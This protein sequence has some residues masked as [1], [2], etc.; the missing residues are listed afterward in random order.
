MSNKR[1]VL[2]LYP[3]AVPF[4]IRHSFRVAEYD[5]LEKIIAQDRGMAWNYNAICNDD[6]VFLAS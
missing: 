4:F 1:K 5:F 3:T 2:N 6:R